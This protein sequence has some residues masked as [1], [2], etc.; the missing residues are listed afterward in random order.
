VSRRLFAASL[1]AVVF[2]ILSLLVV[3]S[4]GC[5]G[6]APY[7]AGG[8]GAKAPV[9]VYVS[10]DE[11]IARLLLNAFERDTGIPV[12]MVG[13]T[14]AFK[15]TGLAQRIRGEQNRPVADVFWSSEVAQIARLAQE[16]LCVAVLTERT[17]DWPE[18]WRDAKHTWHAFSPRPRV[19]VFDPATL[20]RKAVP[21]SWLEVFAPRFHGDVALAD[22]RFGTTSGHFTAIRQNVSEAQ[23]Q[24]VLE[25]LR[26]GAVRVL[27]GGNAATVAAV[28]RG[29]AV[30][31][32]TD[33]DDVI[34]AQQRGV[35]V[36]MVVP[37]L[38]HDDHSGAIVT[39]N[40]VAVLAGARNRAGGERLVDWLL[41]SR[42]ATLLAASASRNMPLQ[43]DVQQAFPELVIEDLV[44]VDH[45]Q[46]ARSHEQTLQAVLLALRQHAEAS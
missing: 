36:E 33:Y 24:T 38:F 5:D 22:P 21:T 34:A 6:T 26:S 37:R 40:A 12:R 8:A 10:A 15:S 9:V 23:W 3:Q 46:A 17:G 2:S 30:L 29:E 19:L 43:L 14:E 41:G 18:Q 25:Q 7:V 31:G 20:E 42:A 13:D 28:A 45:A 35:R 27:P 11:S 32:C 39:P 1:C 4:T 16:D 44:L